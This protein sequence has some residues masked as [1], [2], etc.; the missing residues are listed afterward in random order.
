MNKISPFL[1][2]SLHSSKDDITEEKNI[3]KK[4]INSHPYTVTWK[5]KLQMK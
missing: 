4:K 5:L 1:K 3:T 2:M